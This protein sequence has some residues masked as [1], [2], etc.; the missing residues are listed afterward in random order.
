VTI[1]QEKIVNV[2]TPALDVSTS[3][4]VG[5]PDYRRVLKGEVYVVSEFPN[6]DSL[7]REVFAAFLGAIERVAGP[8][9]AERASRE[10]VERLHEFMRP[11]DFAMVVD[12]FRDD[13]AASYTL[14]RFAAEF[15]RDVLGVR[16]EI[17]IDGRLV[18]RIYPPQTTV[19]AHCAELQA[20]SGYLDVHGPHVESWF[21]HSRDEINLWY[22]IGNV[23]EG[24]GLII[25]KDAFK[26]PLRH[27]ANR[28][29]ARGQKIG[30]P[31]VYTLSPGGVLVFAGEHLHASHINVTQETRVVVTIR[32]SG[33]P[34]GLSKRS[35]WSGWYRSSTILHSDP[36]RFQAMR[37]GR[38]IRESRAIYRF[39]AR[40]YKLQ[41]FKIRARGRRQTPGV[42]PGAYA[43]DSG[44]GSEPSVRLGPLGNF[45]PGSSVSVHTSRGI[46]SVFNSGGA[47]FIIDDRCPHR[48]ASLADGWCEGK[49]VICPWHG[50]RFDL[51][52]G[53]CVNF[54][55]LQIRAYQ[56]LVKDHTLFVGPP[57][58]S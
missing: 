55:T 22:A 57:I 45:P 23:T 16:S 49:V 40:F 43:G 1:K 2:N 15:S 47:L 9:L 17:W 26:Q 7:H 34:P 44:Q 20:F 35:K 12:G 50:L 32:L 33:D 51:S 13:L 21:G 54:S 42:Q 48:G 11:A 39:L 30:R 18:P 10:G 36:R 8:A 14:Y 38:L 58:H 56:P 52:T 6:K 19:L 3:P 37:K 29:L 28:Y 53:R 31:Y 5:A 41:R 25:Y 46:L 4:A 27:D 24:N